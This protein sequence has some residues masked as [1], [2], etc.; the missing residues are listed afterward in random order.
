LAP[1][2][3]ALVCIADGGDLVKPGA[4]PGGADVII[5]DSFTSGRA[6]W[7]VRLDPDGKWCACDAPA[8]GPTESRDVCSGG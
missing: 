1:Q 8:V 5:D 4:G 2:A 7:D 3:T 6:W